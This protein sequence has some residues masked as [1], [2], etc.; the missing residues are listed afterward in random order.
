MLG[1]KRLKILYKD[2]YCHFLNFK[3]ICEMGV[4][5]LGKAIKGWN[6]DFIP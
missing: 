1:G 3:K 2:L 6:T 4:L 5:S